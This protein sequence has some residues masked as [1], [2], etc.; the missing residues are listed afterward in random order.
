MK[1]RLSN[2][3]PVFLLSLSAGEFVV[4]EPGFTP[5]QAK[6]WTI[7]AAVLL[8]QL[9]N[10]LLKQTPARAK[11]PVSF[12]AYYHEPR[13]LLAPFCNNNSLPQLP[14]GSHA[15]PD[16]TSITTPNSGRQRLAFAD[17]NHLTIKINSLFLEKIVFGEKPVRE[18]NC[19]HGT[20]FKLAVA[21]LLHETI[22]LYDHL[23]GKNGTPQSEET[24][25]LALMGWTQQGLLF[26]TLQQAN[27]QEQNSPDSYEFE[28]KEETLAVN[29]EYFLLDSEFACRRPAVFQYFK[30]RFQGFDPFP[31]RSCQVN[32][33]L[34][35]S[36]E[37][38]AARNIDP[39]QIYQVH[40]LM[41]AS[42]QQLMS[43]WGHAMLRLVI[44]APGRNPG[45]DCLTKD[46]QHHLVLTFEAQ[47]P[48]LAT[49]YIFNGI[50]GSYP[51]HLSVRPFA[52]VIQNYTRYELRN[53]MSLPLKLEQS[54]VKILIDHALERKWAYQGHFYFFTDNCA[55]EI[56]R[57]LRIAVG[58][59][60]LFTI[61]AFTPQQ[62]F[63]DLAEGGYL[64]RTWI[65]N[66]FLAAKQGYYYFS[67]YDV[68]DSILTEIKSVIP[69]LS[70]LDLSSYLEET[71]ALQRRNLYE[72][73]QKQNSN[74]PVQNKVAAQFL[75][76]E[77]QILSQLSQ[78]RRA[79][80]LNYL[81]ELPEKE[82]STHDLLF[83][84]AVESFQ[85]SNN[86]DSTLFYEDPT[87]GYGIPLFAPVKEVDFSSSKSSEEKRALTELA[88]KVE[89]WMDNK[90]PEIS[91]EIKQS[92]TNT[93]YFKSSL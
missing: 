57:L 2:F 83:K 11:I 68:F 24:Y 30:S 81:S 5:E 17:F 35:A 54:Q 92:K 82:S 43:R 87:R 45:P 38:P 90:W 31:Q 12:R 67:K 47:L 50:I 93:V 56:L 51:L 58:K 34:P 65:T 71:G 21:T 75:A 44:C 70:S 64:E 89:T 22:H 55:I 73:F 37:I 8:H 61:T 23:L 16:Q 9:K 13:V 33:T 7:T 6:A 28:S 15:E 59:E 49:N 26:K 84:N 53:V 77:N 39:T 79:Q 29:M 40:Y 3:L 19:S 74:S 52:D 91:A 66:P 27:H 78:K 46:V 42:G 41:A 48:E 36:K 62:L 1:S 63:D 72:A 25:F 60:E 80:A 32:Y 86:G 10:L 14:E 69:D 76:L 4:A 88:Q 18:F 20:F 85:R